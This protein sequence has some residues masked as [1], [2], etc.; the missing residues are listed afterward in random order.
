MITFAGPNGRD[1]TS[2]QSQ[3]ARLVNLWREPVAAG[4]RT[5]HLLRAAYGMEFEASSGGTF[6][7]DMF[8]FDD[9]VISLASGILTKTSKDGTFTFGT[10]ASG[11]TGQISR[12]GNKVTVTSGGHFYVWDAASLVLS[13][14][15][16]APF[17]AFGS[18]AYLA[19]RT[20]LSEEGG[21]R[22]CWSNIADPETMPGL[23]VA[24]AESRDDKLLRIIVANGVAM[25]FGER[26]TELW[27]PAGS[28]ASAFEM[29]GGSVVDR[30]LKAFG[31]AVAIEGGVFCV[32]NDGIAYVVAGNTWQPVSTPAVNSAIQD[33]AANRCFYW[34]QRGHKF[35]AIGFNDRPAWVYDITTGEWWERAEGPDKKPWRATGSAKMGAS[36]LVGAVDGSLYRLTPSATDAGAELYREAVSYP[37]YQGGKPFTVAEVEILCQHGFQA[38]DLRVML[39]LGDGVHF[40]A[41]QTR[42][43][44]GLG[45]FANRAMF[46]A[47]GRHTMACAK[48]AITDPVDA[49]IYADANVRLA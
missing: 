44:G 36:W 41:F 7:R 21:A 47:L 29:I 15:T 43:F 8:A 19:G 6:V 33:G 31:L 22:W 11:L 28:G 13:E 16:S 49:P 27:A 30:G 46:R 42:N 39:A 1:S 10:V 24:T 32:G 18:V 3:T 14:V 17:T 4:G 35:A 9:A 48:I 12:N 20:L 38:S 5:Q 25:L 34:E 40:R 37:V 23:N 26:S 2:P 45:G